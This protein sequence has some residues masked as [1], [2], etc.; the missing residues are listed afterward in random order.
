MS[1]ENILEEDAVR[2]N[3]LQGDAACHVPNLSM[4]KESDSESDS[5]SNLDYYP[6][7]EDDAA[8][9]SE[10]EK[11]LMTQIEY[12]ADKRLIKVYGDTIHRNSGCH[13][14]RGITVDTG[15]VWLYDKVVHNPHPMYSPPKGMSGN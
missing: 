14:N 8:I 1:I 3:V 10:L 4:V 9:Y 6:D 12:T 2:P 15:M 5:D 7:E 13:L 11:D